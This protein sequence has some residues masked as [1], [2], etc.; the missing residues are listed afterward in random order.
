MNLWVISPRTGRK[1]AE[2]WDVRAGPVTEA[3]FECP[4]CHDRVARYNPLQKTDAVDAKTG[5]QFEF[6]AYEN[7]DRPL[8]GSH[9]AVCKR[10]WSHTWAVA[11]ARAPAF[12]FLKKDGKKIEF[13]RELMLDV[14]TPGKRTD[15]PHSVRD[16]Y[17]NWVVP[18]V[19]S[20]IYHGKPKYKWGPATHNI[21]EIEAQEGGYHFVDLYGRRWV[22]AANW[23][24]PPEF[25]KA[26]FH[27]G[28]TPNPEAKVTKEQKKKQTKKGKK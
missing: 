20:D 14:V 27:S 12:C 28:L 3:V 2:F 10:C 1:R 17:G 4:M 23:S 26:F 15:V 22:L 8:I 24:N 16:F 18:I 5:K 13:M 25:D 6:V 7:Y 9:K 19:K 11:I 21:A